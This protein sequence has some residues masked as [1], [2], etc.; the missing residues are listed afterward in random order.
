MR[1][2][3]QRNRLLKDGCDDALLDA[4]DESVALGGATLLHHRLNLFGRLSS[5]VSEVYAEVAGSERLA[6]RYAPSVEGAEVGMGRDELVGLMLEQMRARRADDLRRA[7]TLTGPHRDDVVF[8]IDGRDAVRTGVRASSAPW[9]WPGRWLRCACARTSS[10]SV[11]C[12]CST[13]S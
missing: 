7:Q 10:A 8:E 2:V 12:F 3:E 4:W 9:P 1:S 6:C 11:R 13:T 5:L